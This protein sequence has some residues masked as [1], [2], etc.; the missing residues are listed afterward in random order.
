M[1][2]ELLK[3]L[4][5][6]G[7]MKRLERLIPYSTSNQRYLVALKPEHPNGRPFRT[8]VA[9]EGYYVEEHKAYET[10]VKQMQELY[11]EAGL[12]LEWLS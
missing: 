2:R 7:H 5:D 9:Y 3:Y 6:G 8:P 12:D 10:A 4:C 11:R 1:Y